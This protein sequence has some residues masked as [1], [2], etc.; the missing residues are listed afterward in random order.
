MAGYADLAAVR[1]IL[2]TP[3]DPLAATDPVQDRL[4]A[5]NEALSR[6]FDT[7]V[8]RTWAGDNTA[9]TRQVWPG[10]PEA[11]PLLVL[12]DGGLMSLTS[13]TVGPSW[14]GSA[15]SGGTVLGAT[16]VAPV[17]RTV[18]GAYLA[19]RRAAGWPRTGGPVLVRGVW[20][21]GTGS[22]PADVVE[23]LTFVVAEEYRQER[24]S[25]EAMLGPDGLQVS[26]RNPWA[27]ERVR[28]V[29]DRYRVV[30]V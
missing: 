20:A 22:V 13:V 8:G 2:D 15:W 19:L 3:V 10:G 4:E 25:P 23:A 21:D 11:N 28:T 7:K 5:L 1:V 27:Y 17:Q 14:T 9:Q 24:A 30:V 12:P 16:D 6:V 29:V 18:D 26:T